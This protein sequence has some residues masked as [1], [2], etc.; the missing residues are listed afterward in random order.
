MARSKS[1]VDILPLSKFKQQVHIQSEDLRGKGLYEGVPTAERHL[2][3]AH[4]A[5]DDWP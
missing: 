3:D 2:A 4:D 1:V 5:A